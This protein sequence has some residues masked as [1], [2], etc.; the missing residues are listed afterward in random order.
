M[1]VT[2]SHNQKIS[3][4]TA[5]WTV[6]RRER[7]TGCDH[8]LEVKLSESEKSS[9]SFVVLALHGHIEIVQLP[10]EGLE[11]GTLIRLLFPAVFHN[12]VIIVRATVRLWHSIT[13]NRGKF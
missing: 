2:P 10:L 12:G 13:W 5:I 4:I 8:L 7:Q 11:G 3:Q 9:L 1:Q 6:V